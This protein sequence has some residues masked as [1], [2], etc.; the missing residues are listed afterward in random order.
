MSDSCVNDVIYTKEGRKIYTKI[1]S[2]LLRIHVSLE[3]MKTS[4]DLVLITLLSL[5]VD[6]LEVSSVSASV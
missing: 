6:F 4:S 3:I 1:M 2:L 5:M